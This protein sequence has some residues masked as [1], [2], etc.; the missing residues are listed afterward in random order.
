MIVLATYWLFSGA[1]RL[2]FGHKVKGS[3]EWT[4][5]HMQMLVPVALK[6]QPGRKYGIGITKASGGG[7]NITGVD[8]D[9]LLDEWNQHQGQ[10]IERCVGAGDRIVWASGIVG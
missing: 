5:A 2:A 4:V 7:L 6:R 9:G 10:E 8:K 3:E 1:R